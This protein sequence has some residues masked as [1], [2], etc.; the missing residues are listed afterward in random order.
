MNWFHCVADI[1]LYCDSVGLKGGECKFFTIGRALEI[2][3][4]TPGLWNGCQSAK[5]LAT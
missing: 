1:S 4:R 3:Y 2:F 5:T